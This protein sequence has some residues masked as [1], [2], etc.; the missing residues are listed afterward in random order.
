MPEKKKC[1]EVRHGMRFPAGKEIKEEE[2]AKN[3]LELIK[4]NTP[5]YRK[6]KYILE[7]VEAML[8]DCKIC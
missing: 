2:V 6:A 3:V 8:N 4:D 7:I 1:Y 5:T